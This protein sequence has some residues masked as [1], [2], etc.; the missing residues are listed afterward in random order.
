[1]FGYTAAAQ[2]GQHTVNRLDKFGSLRKAKAT[3]F[4]RELPRGNSFHEKADPCQ[5]CFALSMVFSTF[6]R[7]AKSPLRVRTMGR[8][9]H[10]AEKQPS[11]SDAR[12]GRLLTKALA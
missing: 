11:S 8:L 6:S 12:S 7:P 1:M 2:R 10:Q 9:R 3:D 5:E 4:L